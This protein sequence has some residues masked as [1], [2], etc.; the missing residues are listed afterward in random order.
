PV[1]LVGQGFLTDQSSL[2]PRFEPRPGPV[3][4]R[5]VQAFLYEG[6]VTPISAGKLSFFAQS[7]VAAR[8]NGPIAVTAPGPVP[9]GPTYTLLDSDPADL[10]VR[11]LPVEG[12]L[13]GFNG[14]VG[15]FSIGTPELATNITRVG[16]PVKLSVRVRG[17]GNL[18]RVVPPPPPRPR[19]WQVLSAGGDNLPPQIIQAQ[20]FTT[21]NY[22][23]I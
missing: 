4:G 20:G 3:P 15:D 17:D 5:N 14:A 19:H 21:F 7:F 10:E 22:T 2:H 6:I 1:Q 23:L 13:P 16:D 8:E 12:R 11:P 9:G 18:L